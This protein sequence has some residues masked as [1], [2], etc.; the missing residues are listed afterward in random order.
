MKLYGCCFPYGESKYHDTIKPGAFDKNNGKKVPVTNQYGMYDPGFKIVGNAE[1]STK[2]DG[3]YATITILQ[4]FADDYRKIGI[5]R[6][7]I[8]GH[9]GKVK[10]NAEKEII[11][12]DV[13]KVVLQIGGLEPVVQLVDEDYILR[14]EVDN[15]EY[16]REH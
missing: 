12:A 10:H 16:G 4:Q 8:G 15:D 6:L 2:P 14:P 11:D 3:L 5:D 1:L 13:I 7:G 9:A